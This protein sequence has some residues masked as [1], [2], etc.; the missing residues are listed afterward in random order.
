MPP[1]GQPCYSGLSDEALKFCASW[2]VS[3]LELLVPENRGLPGSLRGFPPA[4]RFLRNTVSGQ[5]LGP[6]SSSASGCCSDPAGTLSQYLAWHSGVS[7]PAGPRG[8][9]AEEALQPRPRP[10]PHTWTGGPPLPIAGLC[11]VLLL[12]GSSAAP[13]GVAV[14]EATLGG[15]CCCWS[16]MFFSGW[17]QNPCPCKW[18]HKLIH[19]EVSLDEAFAGLM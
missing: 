3:Q 16:R 19:A 5:W 7:L 13:G 12:T 10:A 2:E 17:V 15:A 9:G 1:S 18:I 8:V 4:A 11:L 6:W 14:P